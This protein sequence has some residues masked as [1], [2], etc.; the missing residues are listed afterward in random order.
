MKPTLSGTGFGW[1]DIGEE[2]ISHD[3]IIRLGG[4]VRKRKKKLSKEIYGTSHTI[5]LAEAEYVY[6]EGA[7]GILIGA[8]QFGRVRLSPEAKSFFAEKN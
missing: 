7:D 4:E 1:I 2:R 8:G 6:Q 3:I 5:S